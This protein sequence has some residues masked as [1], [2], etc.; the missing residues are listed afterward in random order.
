MAAAVLG[1]VC[2]SI[3]VGCILLGVSFSLVH[4]LDY[5][6]DFNKNIQTLDFT[7][8]LQGRHYLG[9]GHRLK[10]FPR[11]RIQY[12]P[13]YMSARTYDGLSCEI[14]TNMQYSL[15]KE[16]LKQLY[17]TYGHSYDKLALVPI[18]RS[19]LRD[20]VAKYT[21]FELVSKRH[22]V[23]DD[24]FT[25][26]KEALSEVY[27]DLHDLELISILWPEKIIQ[28]ITDTAVAVQDVETAK[29][30]YN[31]AVISAETKVI[32]AKTLADQLIYQAN[33]TAQETLAAAVSEEA[34]ILYV[35]ES[36]AN[37][38]SYAS[39]YGMKETEEISLAG[40]I[41]SGYKNNSNAT[42]TA[43]RHSWAGTNFTVD[44][45]QDYTWLKYIGKTGMA[46]KTVNVEKPSFN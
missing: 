35:A 27:I 31:I 40:G 32:A 33:A 23:A 28:A 7:P 46:R 41:G 1:C 16:N 20:V 22:E 3:V 12:Q 10:R 37:W 4:P 2:L 45:L 38:M 36:Q 34:S 14:D 11:R 39:T 6:I 17:R 43:V 24:M 30:E 18:T 29:S 8:L 26:A 15:Q 25:T 19:V 5:G 21:A 13:K 44:E 42:R 9:V